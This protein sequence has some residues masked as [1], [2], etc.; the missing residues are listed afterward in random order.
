[1]PR[2][3]LSPRI[4]LAAILIAGLM[5]PAM[6]AEEEHLR[7]NTPGALPFAEAESIYQGLQK[8]MAQG[9]APARDPIARGYPRWQRFNIAPY[10][11]ETH[12]N[13]YA[14]NFANKKAADAGY[15]R[16]K[17]GERMPPGAVVVK[18]SFTVTKAGEVFPGALFFMEKLVP[19]RS[20]DTG[21]WR[22]V[23][24]LPD[25]SY[26]GDTTGDSPEDVAFC[27]TCHKAMAN[28]DFL[29][30]LPEEYRRR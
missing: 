2:A 20:P 17:Q 6:A 29:F 25:G 27:F 4:A 8:D 13:R 30:F 19:G 14:N 18:D 26:I 22:F 21:D 10:L 24:I 23:L 12:C 28:V 3:C 1:M 11:S 16:L 15:G 5:A 7:L 9:Y